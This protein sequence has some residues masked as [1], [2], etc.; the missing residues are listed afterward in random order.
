ME[1]DGSE[2]ADAGRLRIPGR[3]NA[4]NLCGAITATLLLT[5]TAPSSANLQAVIE[6]YDGLPS[7]CQTV[8]VRDGLTYV[9]D[10]LASNPFATVMSLDA[11]PDRE[12][13]LILGGA[14]RGV[15]MT[16]LVEALTVRR[17]PPLV[18]VIPPDAER[19]VAALDSVGDATRGGKGPVRI[20]DDLTEA[21]HKARA[22]DAVRGHRPVLSG[23]IGLLQIGCL[24]GGRRGTRRMRAV[25]LGS[26]WASQE[27]WAGCWR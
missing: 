12:L 16:A 2:V 11:F 22:I 9:D 17:P 23:R 8:G 20:A 27:A 25:V 1:V 5:G 18:I 3:H 14:D 19:V 6:Q 10:A 13:T 15:A 21:V 7:R 4:W 24:A 26:G